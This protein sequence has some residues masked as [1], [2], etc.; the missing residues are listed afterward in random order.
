MGVLEVV[1]CGPLTSIQDHGRIGLARLGIPRSGAM[2]ALSL[3]LANA[4]VGNAPGEA[5]IE[6]AW[7]GLTLRAHAAPVTLSVTGVPAHVRRGGRDGAAH[8]T[9]VLQPGE[10]LDV[11]R[12]ERGVFMY[13]AAGGGFEI[14]PVLASRSLYARGAIGGLDGRRLAAGDRLAVRAAATEW[15]GGVASD[16]VPIVA[17]PML[18]VL[19]GPEAALFTTDAIAAFMSSAYTV[20]DLCDRMAY[21]LSGP[22]LQRGVGGDL[23]STGT[24]PGAV[25]V[26][27][28]GQ[29][30]VLMA[31]CQTV[32][33]Y[34][35]IATVVSADLRWL[36]QCRPGAA[37]RFEAIDMDEAHRILR[38]ERAR[39]WC[40]RSR[41]AQATGSAGS[42]DSYARLAA[43][44][45][46][47]T[48]GLDP[49][50]W[51]RQFD[52]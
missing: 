2:D 37:V 48:D 45:D 21:R 13:V 47:V 8:A 43:C 46:Y 35:R 7:M 9:I 14:V 25:Q 51:M 4:L 39:Q 17:S 26:P 31:D 38:A 22:T 24:V 33:G 1:A 3:E 27:P 10:V 44:T 30:L 34:P 49:S 6:L 52:M 11:G 19:P 5:A 50:S 28:D 12:A 16:P 29:P 23:V 32:G 20:T 42:S 18:R 36:A 41:P 15:S 40:L